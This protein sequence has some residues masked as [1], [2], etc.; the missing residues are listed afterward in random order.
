MEDNQKDPEEAMPDTHFQKLTGVGDNWR[1]EQQRSRDLDQPLTEGDVF[2]NRLVRKFTELL[3]Q[4]APDKERL[5]TVDDPA[6]D[7]AEVVQK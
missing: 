6:A 5:V 7:T 4:G 2:K 3:K 1:R